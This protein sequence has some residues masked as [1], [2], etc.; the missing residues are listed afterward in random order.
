MVKCKDYEASN[1]IHASNTFLTV[2]PNVTLI[3][4]KFAWTDNRQ[5]PNRHLLNLSLSC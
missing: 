2:L 4:V 1:V 5:N 3:T